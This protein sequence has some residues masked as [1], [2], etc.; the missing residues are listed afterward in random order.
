[1]KREKLD[2]AFENEM[3]LLKNDMQSFLVRLESFSGEAKTKK[4]KMT[5]VPLASPPPSTSATATATGTGFFG[6]HVSNVTR[7]LLK[8][9]I[10]PLFQKEFLANGACCIGKTR[11]RF[12]L[13]AQ[14][15]R[16]PIGKRHQTQKEATNP[17]ENPSQVS[18]SAPSEEE[19][20]EPIHSFELHFYDPSTCQ[21]YRLVL[22]R[23][24]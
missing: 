8:C 16:K 22:E 18:V 24:D 19:D 23:L 12:V 7:K 20:E 13:F 1:L 2:V 11:L 10:D 6:S 14:K 9:W 4:N 3:A 21:V 15:A 17:S 5:H